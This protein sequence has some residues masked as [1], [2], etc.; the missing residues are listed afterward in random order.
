MEP[1]VFVTYCFG[2]ALGSALLGLIPAAIANYAGKDAGV[3]WFISFIVLML[4]VFLIRDNL[5]CW[6]PLIF[7]VVLSVAAR[8]I[9]PKKIQNKDI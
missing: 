4:T 7:L 2:Y 9:F 1:M 3:W 6:S 8:T 5:L